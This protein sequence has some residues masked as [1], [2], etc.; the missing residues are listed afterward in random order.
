MPRDAFPLRWSASHPDSGTVGVASSDGRTETANGMRM[1]SSEHLIRILGLSGR[2]AEGSTPTPRGLVPAETNF[3][4]LDAIHEVCPALPT[5][6]EI[7]RAIDL[8]FR[9]FVR[10]A[11]PQIEAST[12]PFLRLLVWSETV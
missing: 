8:A 6:R 5:I 10:D 11:G 2:C 9:A 3:P 1:M 4:S 7:E 12:E